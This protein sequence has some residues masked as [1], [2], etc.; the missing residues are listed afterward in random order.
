M[1][2]AGQQERAPDIALECNH[3]GG[4]GGLRALIGSLMG[5]RCRLR[6]LPGTWFVCLRRTLAIALGRKAVDSGYGVLFTAAI[7]RAA[8][9]ARRT[10]PGAWE[11]VR[12]YGKPRLLIFDELGYLPF[13]TESADLF[14]QLASCRNGRG[15]KAA[16]RPGRICSPSMRDWPIAG[17]NTVMWRSPHRLRK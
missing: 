14:F 16:A 11:K 4:V 10:R 1:V 13:D 17:S 3:V 5:R 9:L 15:H 7:G 6:P 2:S 12:Q 8:D